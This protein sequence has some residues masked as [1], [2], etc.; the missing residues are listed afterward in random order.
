VSR[1]KKNAV[2]AQRPYGYFVETEP[3]APGVPVPVA[4]L[5]LTNKE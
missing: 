5:L 3:A 2:D 4:T 1:P